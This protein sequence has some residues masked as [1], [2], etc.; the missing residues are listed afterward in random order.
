[1]SAWCR[2][3]NVTLVVMEA[4]GGYEKLPYYMLWQDKLPCAIVN[5]RSVR[6]FAKGMDIL[7]KTDRIDAGVI[8]YFAQVR[9]IAA[10]PPAPEHQQKLSDLATRLRQLV[11]IRVAELN[12]K[13]LVTHAGVLEDINDM[14]K[15]IERKINVIQSEIN[16]LIEADPLLDVLSEAFREVKGVA[17]RT[18]TTLLAVMPELGLVTNKQASKIAGLAPIANDSGKRNGKR[19]IRGGRP[20]IR[21]ILFVVSQGICKWDEKLEAFHQRLL[22]AGKPAMVAKVAVAHKLLVKLNAIAREARE[23]MKPA[24]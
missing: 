3:N 21:S 23:K 16:Q 2:E 19:S 11:E 9:E 5:S 8:A 20:E 13:R 17:D 24:T 22:D 6:Q 14:L 15:I 10:Q 12:R 7:E 1:L 4:S 18:V